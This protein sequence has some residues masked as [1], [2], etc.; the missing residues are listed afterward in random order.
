MKFFNNIMHSFSMGLL[1]KKGLLELLLPKYKRLIQ[2][3]KKPAEYD[4][5]I[6]LI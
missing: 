4:P 2:S 1:A 3:T 6:A 5:P